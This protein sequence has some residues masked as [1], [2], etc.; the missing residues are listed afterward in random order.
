M[1]MGG[2][3][4]RG[5]WRS[6]PWMELIFVWDPRKAAANRR[7]HGVDFLEAATAFAD[8]LSLTVPDPD[9]SGREERF[10]LLGRSHQNRLLVVVHV[11]RAA[12]EIRII[13]ARRAARHERLQ[14]EEDNP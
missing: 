8:P 13:S 6:N 9:H 7:K 4:R 10:L 3:R 14:Y 1:R 11:E 5:R 2:I 12:N